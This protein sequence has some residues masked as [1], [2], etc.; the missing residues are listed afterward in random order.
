MR[1]SSVAMTT[2]STCSHS[3]Q[4]SQTCWMSGFPAMRWSGFPGNRVD[5]QRAGM[6]TRTCGRS[7][8]NAAARFD[9]HGA[10]GARRQMEFRRNPEDGLVAPDRGLG[11]GMLSVLAGGQD[12]LVFAL[13]P[14]EAT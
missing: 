11:K 6:M 7:V 13:C 2:L 1:T 3:L 8:D 9:F 10:D 14:G 4:R 5:P 12:L